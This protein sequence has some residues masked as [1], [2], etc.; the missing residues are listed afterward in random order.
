M[1]K[2]LLFTGLWLSATLWSA[3]PPETQWTL[4]LDELRKYSS[5]Q[6]GC[7]GTASYHYVVPP[8]EYLKAFRSTLYEEAKKI[9]LEGFA[10]SRTLDPKDKLRLLVMDLESGKIFS[11]AQN[12]FFQPKGI[13]MCLCCSTKLKNCSRSHVPPL[14]RPF[15]AEKDPESMSHK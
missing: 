8:I 11:V 2:I 9:G 5:A 14:G 7:Y 15:F 4:R 12:P 3:V 13:V 6:A 1:G 10:W